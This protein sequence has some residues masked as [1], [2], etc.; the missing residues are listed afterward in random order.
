MTVN[1]IFNII[2][3][4]DG[5]LEKKYAEEYRDYSLKTKKYTVDILMAF[6]L[7]LSQLQISQ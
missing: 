1:F 4:L 6:V 2:P 5:Y 7:T 3:S